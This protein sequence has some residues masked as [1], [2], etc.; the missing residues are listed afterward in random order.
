MAFPKVLCCVVIIGMIFLTRNSVVCRDIFTAY[1][2]MAQLASVELELHQALQEYIS[3]EEAKLVDLREFSK[4]IAK[5]RQLNADATTSMAD[6]A[7]NP[8]R[9]YLM[10]KRFVWHWRQIKEK[11]DGEQGLVLYYI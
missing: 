11:M 1:N 3:S 10:L 7:A 9:A 4:D 5:A 2:H 8:I 6:Y